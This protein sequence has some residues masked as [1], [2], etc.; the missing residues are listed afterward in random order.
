LPSR[1]LLRETPN[2]RDGER[3]RLLYTI[4]SPRMLQGVKCQSYAQPT[5][6]GAWELD[7]RVAR[8]SVRTGPGR[9]QDGVRTIRSQIIPAEPTQE[10]SG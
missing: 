5:K 3:F 7:F 10:D 9:P 2:L 6:P 4:A 1:T 8:M